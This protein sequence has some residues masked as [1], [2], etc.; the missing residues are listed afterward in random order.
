MSGSEGPVWVYGD[1]RRLEQA[2]VNLV[3]NAQKYSPDGTAITITTAAHNDQVYWAVG[4]QGP[5]ISAED[6]RHLFERFFVGDSGRSGHR[7]GVGLGL[8]TVLA[9]AQ[10]HGGRI[11]VES[12]P[13]RGSRFLLFVPVD[14]P[15]DLEP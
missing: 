2:L 7:S 15:E 1:R 14:G 12:E 3:S 9:I 11:D 6:Q 4:D 10:A 8:P 5:G 13:G